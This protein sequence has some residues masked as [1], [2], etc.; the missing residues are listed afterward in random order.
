[1]PNSTIDKLQK[2][3]NL[4]TNPSATEGERTTAFELF[5]RLLHD[6][7]LTL[8]DIKTA[9]NVQNVYKF[10]WKNKYERDIL[11]QCVFK[12]INQRTVDRYAIN[13]RSCGFLLTSQQYNNVIILYTFYRKVWQE[14]VENFLTAFL[15]KHRVTSDQPSDGTP[16]PMD[17]D[18]L[19]RIVAM[20]QGLQ[21]VTD[22]LT[23]RLQG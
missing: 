12:A 16:E 22:P 9:D 4:A 21:N 15:T 17:F 10:T 14:D 3:Y 20:M 7:G 8:E 23:P 2:I 19:Q 11:Y 5:E 1:M 6:S 13:S 18:K